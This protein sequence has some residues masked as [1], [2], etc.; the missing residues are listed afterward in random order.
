MAN[1]EKKTTTKYAALVTYVI[2]LLC[3][4]AGLFVPLFG[5]KEIL[6]LQLPK[7]FNALANRDL[8]S[9]GKDFSY[10]GDAAYTVSLAG[11]GGLTFNF[12]AAVVISYFV[13]TVLGVIALIPVIAGNRYKKTAN[14]FAYIVEVIA[15]IV[16]GTYA[17]FATNLYVIN[18][19]TYCYNLFI[20]LGGVL[21]MLLLQSFI[22]KKGS[23]AAK[24]FILLFSAIAVIA[25]FDIT[26]LIPALASPLNSAANA[27]KLSPLFFGG[28]N[29]IDCAALVLGQD[30]ISA[31]KAV[32]ATGQCLLVC[33]S[34]LAILVIVNF[35]IDIITLSSNTNFGGHV[36]H[37]V[38][39]ALEVA[40]AICIIVTLLIDD[41]AIGLMLLVVA[42]M[43]IV[44][45]IM[46]VIRTCM[47]KAALAKEGKNKNSKISD[48]LF[49]DA[50]DVT[51]SA[52]TYEPVAQPA[53]EIAPAYEPVSYAPPVAPVMPA[54][55][56]VQEQQSVVNDMRVY[57]VNVYNGP[58]DEFI[59]KLTNDEKIEFS[60]LFI[61]KKNGYI[62]NIP[63]YCIG[64]DNRKFFSAVFI[65]LGRLRG[66]L[67]DGLL[68]KMYKELNVF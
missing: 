1:S 36:F 67:S 11:Y 51:G 14:V 31:F 52:T 5:G 26:A 34:A 28:A 30:F 15:V 20:P 27:I 17:I 2:A 45:F 39:Y 10:A 33:T 56:V 48:S 16:L 59:K 49:T 62:P 65:Y 19:A 63:E 53:A 44:Q 3:L 4:I 6:A 25:L 13:I 61:E 57:T 68:N 42:L 54:T 32:D 55:P 9:F 58:V 29:G 41:T 35:F 38:R 43:A 40:L 24:F 7:A 64:G 46:S 50:P 47:Y 60:R 18:K 22:Y 23:G 21:L 37:C 8:L 66:Y 12:M